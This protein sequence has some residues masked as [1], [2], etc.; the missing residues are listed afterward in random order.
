MAVQKKAAVR[1]APARKAPAAKKAAARAKPKVNKQAPVKKPVELS[2]KD[3]A[4]KGVNVYLGMLGVGYDLVQE[5]VEY[6]RNNKLRMKELEKRGVKLRKELRKNMDK[7]EA[8]ELDQVFD[9]V[10][11][12]LDRLQKKLEGL[13]KDMKGERKPA[14]G[15][16]AA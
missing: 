8:R 1:K 12:Q 3:R 10:Q 5:N 2:F 9:A 4:Q 15:A 7:F 11:E 6:V 16:R 13:A 14:R